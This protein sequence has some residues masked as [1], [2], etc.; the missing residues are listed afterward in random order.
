[1]TARVNQSSD[2]SVFLI[3]V[4]A[5][6]KSKR[7]RRK[8]KGLYRRIVFDDAWKAAIATLTDPYW[9]IFG[10]GPFNLSMGDPSSPA[11]YVVELTLPDGRVYTGHLRKHITAGEAWYE[12]FLDATDPLVA[13]FDERLNADGAVPANA[14]PK[15][16]LWPR[17]IKLSP[18]PLRKRG[19]NG[20]DYLGT[21]WVS[22]RDGRPGG[23]PYAVVADLG[24]TSV[25]TGYV[26]AYN[27]PSSR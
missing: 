11:P 25:L 14:H 17:Q 22:A 21:L 27:K 12:G 13:I 20:A 15:F 26:T 23:E 4:S 2:F 19:E 6:V 18:S 24:R 9:S 10:R 16:N 5:S 1:L 7:Y 8:P 3:V